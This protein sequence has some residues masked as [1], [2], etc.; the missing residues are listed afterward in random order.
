MGAAVPPAR[1]EATPKARLAAEVSA[2]PAWR[3]LR[4]WH[5]TAAGQARAQTRGRVITPSPGEPPST[6]TAASVIP[7]QKPRHRS[8]KRGQAD[9][10]IPPHSSLTGSLAL[11]G[12]SKP[13]TTCPSRVA[14]TLPARQR[15]PWGRD[16][17]LIF[18][19][20]APGEIALGME[21]HRQAQLP[22]QGPSRKYGGKGWATVQSSSCQ[23]NTMTGSVLSQGNSRIAC[24]ISI[25]APVCPFSTASHL[26]ALHCSYE[27]RSSAWFGSQRGGAGHGKESRGSMW[28]IA[29]SG[30]ACCGL[31]VARGAKRERA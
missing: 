22:G 29:I 18:A 11:H 5:R 1:Y 8:G 4:T 25:P 6:G 15:R 23:Q 20:N 7:T 24:V 12:V 28:T 21:R 17:E 31:N 16:W 27:N 19:H 30:V 2:F 9:T 13:W 10:A 14:S 26:P 3:G